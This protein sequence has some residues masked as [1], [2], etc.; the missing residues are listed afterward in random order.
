MLIQK[1]LFI[2]GRF[3]GRLPFMLLLFLAV[4]MIDILGIGLIGPFV[5]LLAYSGNIVDEYPFIESFL[6][7]VDN[8]TIVTYIGIVLAFT[9][10]VKGLVAFF[11]QKKILSL[12]YE[13]R[14]SIVDKL[15]KSY[16]DTDYE[17]IAEKDVSEMVINTNTHVG[18]FI[19]SVF[20]PA[21][22]LIIEIIVV[23]GIFL[24]MAYTSLLL[25][26]V[27]SIFLSLVIGLYFGFVKKR[28]FHY[29][30]VM[31]DREGFVINEIKHLIGAFREIRLLGVEN[32]FRKEVTNH[33]VEFG[34]AGIITRTLHLIS[35]YLVEASV[36]VFVVGIVIYLLNQS[37][38]V[39]SI[40]SLLS[41]F[42]VGALRLIPSFSAIG[43]GMANIRTGTYA[44]NSLYD[45]LT[46]ISDTEESVRS[47]KIG[48]LIDFDILELKDV[49]FSY[50][51]QKSHKVLESVNLSIKNGDFVAIS[52][53]SGSGKSTLM[54]ILTGMLEPT[55][56]RLYLNNVEVAMA[57][58]ID[59]YWWQSKCAYIP[60]SVFLLN[61]SI[62]KNI[63]LGLTDSEIDYERLEL[64]I[65]GANLASVLAQND[66][67][68]ESQVGE[69]GVRLSGGQRQRIALARALYAGREV[70]FMDEAT[71]ALDKG[72]EDEV[73]TYIESLRG[74]VTIILITHSQS[75]LKTC[76]QGFHVLDGRVTRI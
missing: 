42:A 39:E 17:D 20:V 26:G 13:I 2:L 24:L 60:Q 40:F 50:K 47:S 45:E 33:V 57:S 49:S 15:V 11:V 18:L 9:F 48:R 43:V 46:A 68:I 25:V 7:S 70:I 76:N 63:A 52:G 36:V 3:R 12:G 51:S 35:R 29:G 73:M 74:K 54:D 5:G 66:M 67:S 30:Q 55:S 69:G 28:L 16:Q 23:F 64:A 62:K 32:F 75:A 71:S 10:C 53:K 38:S 6:G 14:T 8:K 19:D 58:D 1:T 4:S 59:M 41:V 21:L 61:S 37:T 56:G 31:S 44:L 34:K 65:K 22:R 72:T 27:I